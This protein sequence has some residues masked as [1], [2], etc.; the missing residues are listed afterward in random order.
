MAQMST[1]PI[2]LCD[3]AMLARI[4]VESSQRKEE[5]MPHLSACSNATLQ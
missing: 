3:P 4:M 5:L 1:A 2:R